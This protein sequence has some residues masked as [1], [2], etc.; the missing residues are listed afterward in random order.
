MVGA[1]VAP[2]GTL[3]GPI[4]VKMVNWCHSI[5]RGNAVVDKLTV[6]VSPET[7]R[8]LKTVASSNG[9]SLSDFMV[10]AAERAMM[11]PDRA[12]AARQM[13]LVR[14]LVIGTVTSDEMHDMRAEGRRF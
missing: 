13:D 4:T 2:V 10:Q 7:H 6:Y 5:D 9:M 8:R 12:T 1:I 3:G 14:A 11:A